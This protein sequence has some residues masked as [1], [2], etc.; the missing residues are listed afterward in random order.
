MGRNSY[1]RK[2][3]IDCVD[4]QAGTLGGRRAFPRSHRRHRKGALQL[5]VK[6]AVCPPEIGKKVKTATLAASVCVTRDTP[7]GAVRQ[8]M[9]R[10]HKV[11]EGRSETVL[12]THYVMI[13]SREVPHSLLL[14]F[15]TV[16]GNKNPYLRIHSY[17]HKIACPYRTCRRG[18]SL[19]ITQ[20]SWEL[21]VWSAAP[22]HCTATLLVAP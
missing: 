3:S 17:S 12:L 8:E 4:M 20:R 22:V 18:W 2:L 15:S 13:K 1:R 9:N 11:W 7:A 10:S 5:L 19:V 16:T 21:S 6:Y 14:P